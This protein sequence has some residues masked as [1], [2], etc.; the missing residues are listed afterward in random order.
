MAAV[1]AGTA[2]MLRLAAW[3]CIDIFTSCKIEIGALPQRGEGAG[4]EKGIGINAVKRTLYCW[5][6]RIWPLKILGSC[7]G[8][9]EIFYNT[10]IFKENVKRLFISDFFLYPG[11]NKL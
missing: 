10:N 2:F 8:T 1:A 11:F 7:S 4:L 3:G 6:F 9:Y 5:T